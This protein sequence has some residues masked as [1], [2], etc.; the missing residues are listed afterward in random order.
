MNWSSPPMIPAMQRAG[1]YGPTDWCPESGRYWFR[2][3]RRDR[4]PHCGRMVTARGRGDNLTT[5]EHRYP[6][7]LR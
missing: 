3:E 2:I 7:V 5:P 4:C 1:M 6:K